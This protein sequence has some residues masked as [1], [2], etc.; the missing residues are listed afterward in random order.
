MAR[1]KRSEL[2]PTPRQLEVLQL[3]ADGLVGQQIARRLGITPSSVDGRTGEV[4]R[5]LGTSTTVQA[6]AVA[7]R[8]GLIR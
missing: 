3:L 1:K 4:K 2:T 5:R 8:R 6:V 7:L